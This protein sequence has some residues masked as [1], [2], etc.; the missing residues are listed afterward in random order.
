[1]LVG[2]GSPWILQK[3]AI[4]LP[5]PAHHPGGLGNG[6][7]LSLDPLGLCNQ[8]GWWDGFPGKG[9]SPKQFWSVLNFF[10][11]VQKEWLHSGGW[12]FWYIVFFEDPLNF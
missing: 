4:E 12:I 10:G 9:R 2:P 8:V 11:G 7:A 6:C 5:L 1:M 3:T